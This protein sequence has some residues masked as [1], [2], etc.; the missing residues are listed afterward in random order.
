MK[1]IKDILKKII[2]KEQVNCKNFILKTRKKRILKLSRKLTEEKLALLKL[3]NE[4]LM[5]LNNKILLND[6]KCNNFKKNI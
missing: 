6:D 5:E 1:E 2:A 4:T 3:N